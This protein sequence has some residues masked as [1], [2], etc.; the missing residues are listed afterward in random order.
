MFLSCASL[1]AP[2]QC[3]LRFSS[4]YR[5][6]L[7]LLGGLYNKH[8]T[9]PKMVVVVT[10]FFC[11][12]QAIWFNEICQTILQ[13]KQ[14]KYFQISTLYIF[15]KTYILSTIALYIIIFLHFWSMCNSQHIFGNS[16]PLCRFCGM[17]CAIQFPF[18]RLVICE[19]EGIWEYF[20]ISE[21]VRRNLV[22]AL[23]LCLCFYY[24][25]VGCLFW[26]YILC[27]Y[28]LKYV[29]NKTT[30]SSPNRTLRIV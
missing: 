15:S 28:S 27:V 2:F 22:F 24:V 8:L 18:R 19:Q 21:P 9:K 26:I 1:L 13:S 12:L 29:Y 4:S 5:T 3:I 16:N 10:F 17:I 6:Y 11:K 7:I 23:I 30:L 20:C 25:F 14:A